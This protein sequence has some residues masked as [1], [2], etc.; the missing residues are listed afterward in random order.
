MLI[1]LWPGECMNQLKKMN[2]K[3]HENNGES[4]NKVNVCYRK[5]CRFS[6][7]EFL[8]EHWMSCF[9]S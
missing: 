2:Q 3:V 9:S 8:E 7:N 6:S 5:V 1:H 4:L